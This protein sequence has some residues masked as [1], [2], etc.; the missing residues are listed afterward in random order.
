MIL[1]IVLFIK[2]VALMKC[3]TVYICCSILLVSSCKSSANN[4][5]DAKILANKRCELIRVNH[6]YDSLMNNHSDQNKV[7]VAKKKIIVKND[8]VVEIMN[9]I[10]KKSNNKEANEIYKQAELYLKDCK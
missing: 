3:F 8:E 4:S 7:D 10:S 6:T 9:D 2:F 5:D 1:V